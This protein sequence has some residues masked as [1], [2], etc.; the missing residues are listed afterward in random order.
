MFLWRRIFSRGRRKSNA[1]AD[2][3]RGP[4]QTRA[5]I[6]ERLA[7]LR[8]RLERFLVVRRAPAGALTTGGGYRL[9]KTGDYLFRL[10]QDQDAGSGTPALAILIN[11]R[12]FLGRKAEGQV[13]GLLHMTEVDLCRALQSKTSAQFLN[14]AQ[15]PAE[16]SL[17]LFQEL[18]GAAN[19]SAKSSLLGVPG[20][21]PRPEELLRWELFDVDR[22][23]T[24][25]SA[26]TLAHV[27]VH[28]APELEQ[29][30]LSRCSG[31][32]RTLLLDE[33]ALLAS[34]GAN[35]ELNPGSRNRGLLDFEAA[36]REFREGLA[37]YQQKQRRDALRARRR[38]RTATEKV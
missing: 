13:Q 4:V 31:R 20:V 22:M 24:G 32:L 19:A 30:L 2:A 8:A 29:L 33:L 37:A 16:S 18:T 17:P 25:H 28:A 34:P 38:V 35:P 6:Q 7:D 15:P 23:I 26:N 27:L 3:S 10:E 5:A 14:R 12:P 9:I 21:L 1:S 36:L 11:T